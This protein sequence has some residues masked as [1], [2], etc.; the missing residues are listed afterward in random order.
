MGWR[1]ERAATRRRTAVDDWR[2]VRHLVAV[3]ERLRRVQLECD[4]ALR[5]IARFDTPETAFYVDPPYPASTRGERWGTRA[6]GHE[7]TDD[8]HRRLAEVLHAVRGMAV[9]S[10]YPCP[11]YRELYGD[12]AM[13]TTRARTHGRRASTEALWLS[14]RAAAR[15]G[16]RQLSLL[17]EERA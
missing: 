16:A 15:L 4:D 5:V 6:Y 2:D 12:W 11:L 13:A 14:P 3:V 1:F 9:V 10:G 17:E 8:G 7:L